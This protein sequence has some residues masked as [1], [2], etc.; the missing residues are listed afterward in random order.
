MNF[1][2]AV[3]KKSPMPWNLLPLLPPKNKKLK[4]QQI[5]HLISAWGPEIWCFLHFLITHIA[6]PNLDSI[7]PRFPVGNM[8]P[9][10]IFWTS[11]TK[12]FLAGVPG[13]IVIRTLPNCWFH[14]P[15]IQKNKQF[16]FH[17]RL[18]SFSSSFS[19]YDC[20]SSQSSGTL[21]MESLSNDSLFFLVFIFFC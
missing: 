18:F 19:G 1:R 15:S 4:I 21:E 14:C 13:K 17:C 2:K 10:W 12:G 9:A 7:A 20:F 11:D 5:F 6:H 3:G 16:L 8:D